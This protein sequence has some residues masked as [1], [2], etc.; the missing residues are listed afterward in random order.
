MSLLPDQILELVVGSIPDFGL[1]TLLEL[2][3]SRR[4][5]QLSLEISTAA[6]IPGY[7][8]VFPET[9]FWAEREEQVS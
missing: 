2:E 4:Q 9:D 6:I 8:S 5:A 3:V 1:G 7:S